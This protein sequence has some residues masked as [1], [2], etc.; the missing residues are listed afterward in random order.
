MKSS[1]AATLG[2]IPPPPDRFAAGPPE[3]PAEASGAD[4]AG[5]PSH[6]VADRM[7]WWRHRS[8][9]TTLT[10]WYAAATFAVLSAYAAAVFVV[11][12]QDALSTLDE[13]LRGDFQWAHEMVEQKPDGSFAWFDGDNGEGA[14]WLQ[15]WTEGGDLLYRSVLAERLPIAESAN[16]ASRHET[17][18]RS[19]TAAA[20][21]RL[22]LLGREAAIG[23]V[24]VTI[25]VARAEMPVRRQLNQFGLILLLGL[26]LGAAVAGASGYA[27]ARRAL[28]PVGRMSERAHTI[29]AERLS[30]RLPVD[31]PNDELGR[32]ATVFN[33][34]LGRLESSFTQMRQ[35]TADVSHELRTPLT[36]IRS[37][38]EVGLRERRDERT[39]RTI[40]GSM[41]E[42]VDRLTALVDRLLT[43]SRAQTGQASLSPETVNLR[44][45]VDDVVA[46]LGV[47]AD[48]KGQRITIACA[49][50]PRTCAD[51]MMLRQAL[52]NLLD[53]AVKYTPAGGAIRI[54]VR[55]SGRGPVIDVSDNGPGI[56]PDLRDRIFDRYA[57]GGDAGHGRGM[58]LGL[59]IAKYAVE[60]NGGTLRLENATAA[61]S[62][63][64]IALRPA[65]A[66]GLPAASAAAH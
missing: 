60:A 29:T 21:V 15:V 4:G 9:R 32:L 47:L 2:R 34:T 44:Q 27:L 17:G 8:I 22:R 52:I 5:T 53:N 25:Q 3:A 36:A 63:F 64:R 54:E 51:R 20:N 19:V 61:G 33:D 13:R 35:F 48:E 10:I 31:N 49:G 43:L 18:I 66:A 1:H 39:Y 7:S 57:R 38:G 58:G 24:P 46:H 65:D 37:V 40:I 26:P 28:A 30:A 45:L 41:L 12:R 42:E 50:E 6:A 14:P 55:E 16:M 56:A 11:V 23:D 59:S 62:T